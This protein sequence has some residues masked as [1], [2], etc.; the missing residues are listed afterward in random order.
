M[1]RVVIVDDSEKIRE[2]I[3]ALLTE[4]GEIRVVGQFGN[5]RDALDRIDSL[6]PDA[7]ILDIRLPDLS[8]IEILKKIKGRM[9]DV[10]V[11]MFTNFDSVQYRAQ[12]RRLG[13]DHFLNKALEFEKITDTV[14]S[15]T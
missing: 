5:G 14:L 6:H 3:V 9:P 13:A 4:S 11:T 12:C 10:K 8:G 2:R 7:A 1:K 15:D